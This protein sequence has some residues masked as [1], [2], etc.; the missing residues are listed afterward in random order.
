MNLE[1]M[2]IASNLIMFQDGLETINYFNQ[3]LED[4]KT[5]LASEGNHNHNGGVIQPVSLL[6]LDVNMP[7]LNGLQVLMQVKEKFDSLE[8][9]LL[10]SRKMISITETPLPQVKV[11]RPL[12]AYLSQNDYHT[13]K[14][15]CKPE[16]QPDIFLSKPL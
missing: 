8:S 5:E 9:E 4:L 3:L 13:I 6:I 11:V 2:E 12:I 16:E 7:I 15:F 1:D 10:N 14:M